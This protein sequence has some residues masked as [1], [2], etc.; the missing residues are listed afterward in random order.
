MTDL[1]RAAGEYLALR[2]AVGYKLVEAERILRGFVDFLDSRG[3]S[4]RHD[5]AGR[6]VG[7]PA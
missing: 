5:A 2:R 3:A 4:E 7:H 1:R 6:G